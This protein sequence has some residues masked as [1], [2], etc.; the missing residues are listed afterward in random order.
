MWL[1]VLCV[2]VFL[3]MP[4][5]SFP[6]FPLSPPFTFHPFTFHL[7]PFAAK[8]VKKAR[9]AKEAKGAKEA[10]AGSEAAGADQTGGEAD[11]GVGSLAVA[12]SGAPSATCVTR[13]APDRPMPSCRPAEM[14]RHLDTLG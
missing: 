4:S 12:D 5:S 8:A 11:D 13:P 7:S 1:D 9:E 14:T 10:K 3:T 2:A 6:P